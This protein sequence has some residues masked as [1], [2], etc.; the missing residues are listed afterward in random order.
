[1]LR[2]VILTNNEYV[3][4]LPDDL[5]S[6][7]ADVVFHRLSTNTKMDVQIGILHIISVLPILVSMG[8]LV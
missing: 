5:R 8:P 3:Y 1:M 6:S 7:Y 4:S 2:A